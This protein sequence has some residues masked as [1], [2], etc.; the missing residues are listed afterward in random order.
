MLINSKLLKDYIKIQD[1][2]ISISHVQN[3]YRYKAMNYTTPTGYKLLSA[4]I[5]GN[6]YVSQLLTSIIT[7]N[8]TAV[9]INSSGGASSGTYN[10]TVRLLF[11]KI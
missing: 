9:V 5:I 2:V 7:L 1:E 8:N 4:S 10:I 6:G 3:Q 11:I